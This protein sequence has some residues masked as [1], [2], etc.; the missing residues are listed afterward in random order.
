MRKGI[1]F[2]LVYLIYLALLVICVLAATLYVQSLLREYEASQPER[3]VE[4]VIED[5]TAAA[6]D[7]SLWSA[8]SFPQTG[9]ARFESGMDIR[10]AYLAL[11]A[12]GELT[13]SQSSGQ[14]SEDELVYVIEHAGFP[15]AEVTLAATGPSYTKLSLFTMRPWA[16]DSVRPLD[17]A[18]DYTLTVPADFNVS[19]NGVSLTAEDGVASG[20]NSIVYTVSGLYLEPSFH[21]TDQS[22]NQADYTIK[23]GKVIPD[24]YNYTLTI[25]SALTVEL[26]GAPH[27]GE[28]LADGLT[29]HEIVLL[30]KPTV[31]ISD[32]FG[33]TVNY[34]GG[35][36]L[37][38]TYMTITADSGYTVTV[39][40][41]P[42]AAS[43]YAVHPDY[44][45][46]SEFVPDLPQLC[47]YN[48]AVLQ[49][50]ADITVTDPSGAPVALE[51]GQHVYDLSAR[52]SGLDTVPDSVSSQIDV[53]DVAQKWS[54]F[55][56]A[57][58]SF[59]QLSAYLI[60][61][62]YQYDVAY[63]YAT[64]IDITFIS[65][66]TFYDP[67]FT[68]ISVTN[69][70]WITDDCFSVDISFVKHMRLA[71]NRGDMDDPM[72]DRFYFVRYDDTNDGVDNPTWKLAGMKEIV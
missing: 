56:S 15:L 65:S 44:T 62:S 41:A 12:T 27:P 54:L 67:P 46:F 32:Q 18:H 33:N 19:V 40:G 71:N 34:E 66:H 35:S 47:I 31:L 25:P 28:V 7:G 10:Q 52:A 8:Y 39:A 36:E 2:K 68:D 4:G 60:R 70:V 16:V 29:R 43:T 69:F 48:I 1:S 38:L 24:V 51:A 57:D 23:N 72:N 49:D 59:N 5:M 21:I 58:Y 11:C 63:K 13:Y 61:G 45:L 64:G 26:N 37:P 3:C 55:M 6:Q 17:D 20:S 22:G 53:L 9:S 30:T 14:R 50:D 42:M